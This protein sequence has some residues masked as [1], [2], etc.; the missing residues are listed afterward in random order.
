MR[1]S[2]GFSMGVLPPQLWMSVT[3]GFDMYIQDRTGGTIKT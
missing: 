3:S 2:E 1:T